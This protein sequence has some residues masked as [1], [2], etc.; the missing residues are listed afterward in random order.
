MK[1]GDALLFPWFVEGTRFARIKR[2]DFKAV[3]V[4]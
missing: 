3:V 1:L 2:S 4:P